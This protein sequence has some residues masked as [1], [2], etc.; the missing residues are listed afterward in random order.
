MMGNDI[1]VVVSHKSCGFQGRMG[2]CI[3][4]MKKPV[5]VAPDFWSFSSHIFYQASQ[6]VTVK[7]RVGHSVRRNKFTV[8]NPL[9]LKKKKISML[10]V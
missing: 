8:K 5:V 4:M 1:H 2:R 3:V 9:H 7:F 6:N 10:F